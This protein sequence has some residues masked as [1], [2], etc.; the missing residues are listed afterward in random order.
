MGGTAWLRVGYS[1]RLMYRRPDLQLRSVKA[2]LRAS[3]TKECR[4]Q[5]FDTIDRQEVS[6]QLDLSLLD[7]ERKEW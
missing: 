7:L 2:N 6:E 5:Y 3:T 1:R 4:Q